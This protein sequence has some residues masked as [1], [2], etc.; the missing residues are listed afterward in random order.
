MNWNRLFKSIGKALLLLVII[1][2]VSIGVVLLTILWPKQIWFNLI[3]A[4]IVS[5]IYLVFKIYHES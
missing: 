3:G 4:L 1:T 2:G 5:L